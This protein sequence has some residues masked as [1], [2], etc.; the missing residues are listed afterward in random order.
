MK[1]NNKIINEEQDLTNV[2]E[3]SDEFYSKDS[4][5]TTKMNYKYI[6]SALAVLVIITS[7]IAFFYIKISRKAALD[8]LTNKTEVTIVENGKEEKIK[9]VEI[10]DLVHRMSN[11]II[12]A[13]KNLIWGKEKITFDKIDYVLAA[14]KNEDNYLYEEML[15]WKDKDFS[16]AKDLHNYVWRKLDGNIGK[17]IENDDNNIKE[18]IGKIK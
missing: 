15:K 11:T 13:D 16:N 4:V 9:I 14:V 2:E 12:V 8:N 3:S 17:A 1:E 18:L 10:Y 6:I 7:S 5:K